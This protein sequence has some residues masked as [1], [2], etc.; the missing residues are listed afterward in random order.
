MLFKSPKE[1]RPYVTVLF[2]A[3]SEIDEKCP[4]FSNLEIVKKE[5]TRLGL[6]VK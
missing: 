2:W 5:V 6:D 4:V 3:R 1:T